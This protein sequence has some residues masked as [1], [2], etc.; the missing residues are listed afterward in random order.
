MLDGY[1]KDSESFDKAHHKRSLV[2]TAFSSMKKRHNSTVKAISNKGI[3]I[4]LGP[5]CISYNL[6]V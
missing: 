2:E 1:E 5:R 4:E 6:I 3:M